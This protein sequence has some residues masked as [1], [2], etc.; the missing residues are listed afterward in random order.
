MIW[1]KETGTEM[2]LMETL[3]A[4][5]DGGEEEGQEG[6]EALA[7]PLVEDLEEDSDLQD[8]FHVDA[9][10]DR[11]DPAQDLVGIQAWD[12][13]GWEVQVCRRPEWVRLECHLGEWDHLGGL[14]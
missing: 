4:E 3:E 10:L 14:E 8:L 7:D 11:E 2:D 9:D 5:E 6:G 12:R 13:R 1:E